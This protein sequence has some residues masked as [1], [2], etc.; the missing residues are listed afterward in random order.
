MCYLMEP[1]TKWIIC[2]KDKIRKKITS[3]S[4][5]LEIICTDSKDYESTNRDWL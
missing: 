4:R 2:N 1:N 5:G 3:N